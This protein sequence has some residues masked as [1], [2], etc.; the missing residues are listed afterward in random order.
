MTITGKLV[1][2]EEEHFMTFIVLVVMKIV[3]TQV[4][5]ERM[6]TNFLIILEITKLL[7]LI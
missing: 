1:L 2:V 4:A 7:E 3:I 6:F 5:K